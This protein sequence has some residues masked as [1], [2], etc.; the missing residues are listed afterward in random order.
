[1]H[2]AP[3]CLAARRKWDRSYIT[4]L[5]CLCHSLLISE[6]MGKSVLVEDEQNCIYNLQSK[7]VLYISTHVDKIAQM[8]VLFCTHSRKIFNFKE[9]SRFPGSLHAN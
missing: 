9:F 5:V 4:H 1:M 3:A 6:N 7:I 2:F 8:M